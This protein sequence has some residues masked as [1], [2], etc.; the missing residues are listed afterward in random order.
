MRIRIKS[1]VGFEPKDDGGADDY[2]GKEAEGFVQGDQEKN[3]KLGHGANHRMP[4]RT[5]MVRVLKGID[6]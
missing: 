6:I 2:A 3:E 1:E 5:K 4:P